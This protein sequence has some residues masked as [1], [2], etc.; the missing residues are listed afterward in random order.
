MA[1]ISRIWIKRHFIFEAPFPLRFSTTVSIML[2]R[3]KIKVKI[4]L[5]FLSTES[6][7]TETAIST[8]ATK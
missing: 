3:N 8:L 1:R 5:S 7:K 6:A 4:K 2:L